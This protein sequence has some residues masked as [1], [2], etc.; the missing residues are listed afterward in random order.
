MGARLVRNGV[1]LRW[2]GRHCEAPPKTRTAPTL[3]DIHRG[4]R[5]EADKRPKGQ[6]SQF[7][8]WK[9][10]HTNEAGGPP[11]RSKDNRPAASRGNLRELLQ[12]A[13]RHRASVQSHS[14]SDKRLFDKA[15]TPA[16]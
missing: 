12:L 14:Q 6:A 15:R 2:G 10:L 8:Y 5:P 3:P 13:C 1:T 4:P 9:T 7:F 11:K 16:Q